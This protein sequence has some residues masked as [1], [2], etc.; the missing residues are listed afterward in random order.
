LHTLV[1]RQKSLHDATIK[2]LDTLMDGL[3]ASGKLTKQLPANFA[4]NVRKFQQ[5]SAA[6]QIFTSLHF[7]QIRER[8]FTIPDA[9][10]TTFDWIF[11]SR[12]TTFSSWLRSH[13]GIFWI[14]GKAGSGS[15]L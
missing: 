8:E 5:E 9:H 12:T 11:D 6:Q 2:R 3:E 10:R 1:D 15:Q 4:A 13:G 7:P 14:S